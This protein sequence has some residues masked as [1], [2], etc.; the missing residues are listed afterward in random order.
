MGV[1]VKVVD[2]GVE[3]MCSG[4]GHSVLLNDKNQ[5]CVTGYNHKGQ[6]GTGDKT[7]VLGFGKKCY[8]RPGPCYANNGGCHSA[9]KCIADNKGSVSCGDLKPSDGGYK[10]LHEI[11]KRTGGTERFI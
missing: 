3:E 8:P 6:L 2:S 5:L 11:A 9:R 1:Y 10:N 7:D 4:N